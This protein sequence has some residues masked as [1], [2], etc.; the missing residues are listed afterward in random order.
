MSYQEY[1][2]SKGYSNSSIKRS[3]QHLE[4]FRKWLAASNLNACTINYQDVLSYLSWE[5]SRG[6]KE[7]SLRHY[8][9][10]VRWYYD[11][12][13]ASGQIE[14]HPLSHL[15]L[16]RYYKNPGTSMVH[17]LLDQ[18]ELEIIYNS[19][20]KNK[21]LSLQSKVLLGL[22]IYQGLAIAELPY[23]KSDHI[24]LESVQINIPQSN[25]H[26]SRVLN[27]SAVQILPLS[28]LLSHRKKEDSL[29]NYASPSQSV[30]SRQHLKAQVKRELI[31]NGQSQ[32]GF[33]NLAQLRRSVISL[34][35]KQYNLREAQYLAGHKWVHSTE[36][37][38]QEDIEALQKQVE[39]YH[40]LNGE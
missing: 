13:L 14:V 40:P 20:I 24:N 25:H 15:N 22:L 5:R 19:Y 12:L 33:M 17:S 36:A 35:V 32:I 27:L 31:K 7:V 34:W 2:A 3:S 39:M 26:Q 6:I 30:N 16:N 23:L 1:L 10:Y 21:R 11:Y 8:I 29:L 38:L 18:E 37:Y 28:Q 9:R 4:R